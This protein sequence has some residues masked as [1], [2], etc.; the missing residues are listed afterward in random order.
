MELFEVACPDQ[1]LKL[2]QEF[3]L[4]YL[5]FWRY[6]STGK[7]WFDSL[8]E[9]GINNGIITKVDLERSAA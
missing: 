9:W 4:H 3:P 5:A 1:R 2:K 7:D 6:A 8:A